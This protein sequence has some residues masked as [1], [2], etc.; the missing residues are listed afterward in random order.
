MSVFIYSL[1]KEKLKNSRNKSNLNDYSVTT[2]Q[3]YSALLGTPKYPA[4]QIILNFNANIKEEKNSSTCLF[5]FNRESNK[6]LT[7]NNG[8]I[9]KRYYYG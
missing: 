5:Q 8:Q 2:I 4:I 7:I 1:I 9:T 6:R 3:L